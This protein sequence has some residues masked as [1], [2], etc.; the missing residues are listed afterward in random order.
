VGRRRVALEQGVLGLG[1]ERRRR[2]VQDQEQWTI[3]HEAARQRQLLPL[4][5][6]H[7]DA[8][9]PRR[10]ELRVEPGGQS[11]DDVRST[12]PI[13][14]GLDG[15]NVIHA[16]LVAHADR[17]ARPELEAEGSKTASVPRDWRKH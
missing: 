13:D 3:A 4:P 14:G 16:G 15:G 11:R 17:V 5:E 8:S 2:L 7:F 9:R 6:G 1:V 10:S 12:G